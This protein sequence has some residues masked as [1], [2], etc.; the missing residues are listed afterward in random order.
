MS[1]LLTTDQIAQALPPSLKGAATD[2]LTDKIN[3]IITDPVMAE[4]VRNNFLSYTKVLQ[5]GRFKT[6]DYLNAVIYVSHKLTG[7]SNQDA[8]A[9]TFPTR[10]ANLIAQG[11][12]TKDISSYVSMYNKG[13]LVNLILQ[14]SL[15]PTWV[16]NADVYQKAINTQADLMCNA[17][18]ELVRTQAANSLLTHLAKPKEAGPLIN[19]DM[20]DSSG[21]EELKDMM[22]RVAQSQRQAI[23]AGMTAKQIAEMPLIEGEATRVPR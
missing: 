18:S 20:R 15:V 7:M 13:K 22:T 21:M 9:K 10:M 23:G 14:Q 4:E 3:N 11:T 1:S 6:E 5:E 17:Q 16:L 19:I 12:S 2:E 8:Y